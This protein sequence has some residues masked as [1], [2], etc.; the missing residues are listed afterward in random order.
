MY[1]TLSAA[2]FALLFVVVAVP[3]SGQEDDNEPN[4]YLKPDETWINISGTAVEAEDDAFVLDYGDGVITVEMDDWDWYD[5]N[6]EMLEGDKVRVYG[7]IDDDLYETTTIEA[8]SVYVESLGTYF[9]A[10]AADEEYEDRYDYYID[11]DPIVVGETSVY[12]TVTSV[13]GREFTVDTGVRELTVDT[14]DMLYDPTDDFGY[15]QIDVGD[16]VSVT[17]EMEEEFWEGRELM[18]DSVVTIDDD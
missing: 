14:S 9:Y 1:R 6:A 17:G 4:P 11:Y 7:E 2:L 8:S 10:S 12:G 13:S 5:E 15:Q 18:A 3:A 16:Y